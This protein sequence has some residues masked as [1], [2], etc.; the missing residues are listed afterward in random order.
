MLLYKFHFSYI[1]LPNDLSAG[2][3]K[4]KAKKGFKKGFW[5]VSRSFWRKKQTREYG[6]KQYKNLC[7]YEK[8]KLVEYRKEYY[9]VWKNKTS[10][11]IKSEWCFLFRNHS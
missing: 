8:Q 6:C 2:Y 5:K 11:K 10:S 4:E 3:Y 1:K 7:E 9:E